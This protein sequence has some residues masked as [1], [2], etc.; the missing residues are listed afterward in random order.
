MTQPAA[1]TGPVKTRE[2]FTHHFHSAKWNGFK[3]RD[4]DIVIAT[5]AKS[6][7]TWTQQIISQLI[8][9]GAEGVNVHQL[10]PWVDLRILPPE[11]LAALQGQTHRRL[12]CSVQH[13][14]ARRPAAS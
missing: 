3:F 8:F 6:G 10:S 5:Y 11:A 13:R 9:K 12:L 14:Q 7:T 1:A 2:L 4:D